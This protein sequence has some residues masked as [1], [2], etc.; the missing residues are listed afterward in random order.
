MSV[1]K[2]SA[3]SKRPRL[4]GL[5]GKFGCKGVSYEFS[6][7][8]ESFA[9]EEFKAVTGLRVAGQK[10]SSMCSSKSS[11]TDFHVHFDGQ[12][13]SKR[14]R[15]RIYYASGSIRPAPDETEPYAE[16]IMGWLGDFVKVP[17]AE[18]SVNATFEGLDDKWRSRFNLPFKVT[19][20]G[21]NTEVAI[22]GISMAL[23]KNEAGAYEGT[24]KIEPKKLCASVKLYRKLVFDSFKLREEI[25]TFSDVTNLWVERS[26]A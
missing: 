22:D 17:T 8:H 20:S 19:M 12:M 4:V 5:F 9:V 24:L 16:D 11:L 6:F 25:R 14:I 2:V 26:E 13:Q 10:W 1:S 15:T 18:V 21:S 23:P 3:A 7:P